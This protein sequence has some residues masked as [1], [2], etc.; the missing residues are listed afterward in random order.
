[1]TSS[2]GVVALGIGGTEPSARA[3]SVIRCLTVALCCSTNTFVSA[4]R[5]SSSAI[6][7]SVSVCA[8]VVV[9]LEDADEGVLVDVWLGEV[10]CAGGV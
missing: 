3:T 5:A 2:K 4:I 10:G 9:V 8:F 7:S 6:W 1:M